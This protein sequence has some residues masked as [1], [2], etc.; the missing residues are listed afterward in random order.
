MNWK[1]RHT[2]ATE[3]RRV[4]NRLPKGKP[5]YLLDVGCSEGDFI[6][7]IEQL[8]RGQYD[9]R[10]TGV[11][12]ATEAISYANKRAHSYGLTNCTFISMDAT[13]LSFNPYMFDIIISSEVVEHLPDPSQMIRSLSDLLKKDGCVILTTPHGGRGL[14]GLGSTLFRRLI[15]G[16]EAEHKP[17][18]ISSANVDPSAPYLHGQTERNTGFG[19]IS[20]KRPDQWLKIFKDCGFKIERFIG[21]GGIV[22]GAPNIDNHRILFGLTVIA[23]TILEKLPCSHMWSEITQFTLQKN[24]LNDNKTSI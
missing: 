14:L 9:I 7:L 19:H 21:T 10:Y 17:E 3:I 18:H 12:L 11:D 23:D 22:F 4:L 6:M 5:I 2:I 16:A 15:C 13:K 8:F 24:S 20:V 1:R